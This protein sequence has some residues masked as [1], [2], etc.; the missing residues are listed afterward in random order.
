[1]NADS[2]LDYEQ[3]L[4]RVALD[5]AAISEIE[6]E[7]GS[8]FQ[9]YTRLMKGEWTVGELVSVCH[10]L[11][12]RAGCQCDYMAL[13]Q[14]MVLRGFELYRATVTQLLGRVFTVGEE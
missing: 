11:L 3:R 9:F 7:L 2:A 1:M 8:A 10:I 5:F 6:E 14:Q 12:S 4:Y 13:G